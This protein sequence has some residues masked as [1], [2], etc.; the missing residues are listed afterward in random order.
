MCVRGTEISSQY[1]TQVE[2]NSYTHVRIH[3]YT[4]YVVEVRYRRSLSIKRLSIGRFF[5]YVKS[6]T[7][8]WIQ[9]STDALKVIHKIYLPIAVII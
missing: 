4:R 9:S 2:N 7:Q 6:T 5:Q 1:K 8:H 3:S